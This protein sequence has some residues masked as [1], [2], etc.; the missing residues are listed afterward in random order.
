MCGGSIGTQW[1]ADLLEA[2]ADLGFETLAVAVPCC[3]G[4]TSLDALRHDWPCGFACFEIAVWDPGR[5]WFADDEP[6]S[7]G[8][9]LGHP[10]RQIRAHI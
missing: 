3:G 5:D 7:L 9:T 8:E 10:V 1:W 4:A 6:A 2:H